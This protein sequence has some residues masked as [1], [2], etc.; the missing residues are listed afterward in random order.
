[1]RKLCL[2]VLCVICFVSCVNN[3]SSDAPTTDKDIPIKFTTNI[4]C[5]P[6]R[7]SNN[8]FEENESI[9]V[10]ACIQPAVISGK[11]FIDNLCFT[12]SSNEFVPTQSVYYPAGNVLLDIISYHPYQSAGVESGKMSMPVSV[13]TTQNINADYSYSNFLVASKKGVTASQTAI[14]LNYK[15]KFSKL[16]VSIIPTAGEDINTICD[17]NPKITVSGYY[18][19]ANYD[20]E[21][22]NF[23]AFTGQENITPRGEWGVDN[24]KI[25]GKELILIPQAT[26]SENQYITLEVN[27]KTYTSK[28]PSNLS[29]LS[30]KQCSINISFQTVKDYLVSSIDGAISDWEGDE[31]YNTTAE[32]NANVID[33]STLT[34]DQ[35]NVYKVMCQGEQVAEVCKEY[36]L[37]SNVAAQAIVVYPMMNTNKADLSNGTVLQL[38]DTED[39]IH[40]GK[41]VW[42]KANNQLTYTPGN[43]EAISS[44]FIAGDKSIAFTKPQVALAVIVNSNV[45]QDIRGAETKTYPIVKIGTQYWMRSN[46]AA[47]RYSDGSAIAKNSSMT[48][49]TPGYLINTGGS[50]HFYNYNAALTGKLAPTGWKIPRW[51]EWELLKAYLGDDASLLKSGTWISYGGDAVFPATN[52][53]GF[54]AV[55]VGIYLTTGYI[56]NGSYVAYW[57]ATDNGIADEALSMLSANNATSTSV[58][59]TTKALA[60]R[61]IQQ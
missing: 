50:Y 44:F 26:S 54:N 2:L 36:L 47:T 25:N 41:V 57:T 10:F 19:K 1:M 27:G 32:Y 52:K 14:D 53:S 11:R 9:G 16:M 15:H 23:S 35:S 59:N 13:K 4:G 18:T 28:L 33:I 61:C 31:Q 46:L 43:G 5:L 24:G 58:N 55:A 3:V 30:G 42:N 40:G 22:D 7:I 56:S 60:I 45:V 48:T 21:T 38:L 37:A 34:F 12:C 20:F 51:T 29:L 39:K 6:T 17:A 49:T 8:N